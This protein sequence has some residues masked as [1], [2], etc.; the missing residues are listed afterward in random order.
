M[1]KKNFKKSF[2]RIKSVSEEQLFETGMIREEQNRTRCLPW[3]QAHLASNSDLSP[4]L[5]FLISFWRL[6]L[7]PCNLYKRIKQVNSWKTNKQP[8][9][10]L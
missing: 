1:K 8:L 9:I 4:R 6:L 7:F 5:N 3:N 2:S 10:W